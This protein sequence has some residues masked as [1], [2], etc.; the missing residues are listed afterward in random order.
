MTKDELKAPLDQLAI[1]VQ[2]NPSG[3]GLIKLMWET[4]QYSVAFTVKK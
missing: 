2:R 1:A 4:T 3:G